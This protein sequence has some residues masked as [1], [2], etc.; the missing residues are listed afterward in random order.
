M[1]ASSIHFLIFLMLLL[2]FH[3]NLFEFVQNRLVLEVGQ[4]LLMWNIKSMGLGII[5]FEGQII[6]E[7]QFS[8][9]LS[10]SRRVIHFF[11]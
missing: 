2:A 9:L 8:F 6:D 5:G 1:M 7:K 4:L 11:K 3:L 10:L